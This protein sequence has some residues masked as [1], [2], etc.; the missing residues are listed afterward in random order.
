MNISIN[1][2]KSIGKVL[3]IVDFDVDNAAIYYLFDRDNKSN[4]DSLFIKNMI[5]RL[6]NSRDNEGY[7]R[8]EECLILKKKHFKILGYIKF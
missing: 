5:S 3:F 4:T 8:Q 6:V 1:K 2:H 7:D